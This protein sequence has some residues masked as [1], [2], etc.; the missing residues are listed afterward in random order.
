VENPPLFCQ[1]APM[2]EARK[3]R[4][5]AAFGEAADRYEDHAG[6]QRVVAGAVADLAAQ[7]RPGA[8]TRILEIGCGTGFLTR[9]IAAR[10]P[11]AE[12]V[13]TDLAPAMVGKA[14]EGAM[15]AGTFLPM[16]GEQ[17]WFEGAWFDLI[18]SSLAFQWFD[19]LPGAIARLADLLRPGGSLI[20]S[21]MAQR[22]FA[23]WR[24][25]HAS[26]GLMAGIPD[27]PSLAAVRA[28]LAGYPDA[29][30]FDEDYVLDRGSAKGLIAH[31]KGIGATVPVE[32]RTPLT[33]G[34]LR[35][36]MRA[37]EASGARDAYHVAFGRVTR[38]G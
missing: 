35:A 12:L 26:C 27:Y 4:I 22:S 20:F 3:A 16:D 28:M 13:A 11:D 15:V 9:E 32:G 29:F 36:V 33:P 24:S 25:A 31:L 17:P 6:I 2:S 5:E 14:A 30:A 7:R 37:F 8:G 23:A 10:W 19:D 18:L 34:E 1:S 21:T 38:V